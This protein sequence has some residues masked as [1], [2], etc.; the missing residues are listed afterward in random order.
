MKK[1]KPYYKLHKLLHEIE[2][3]NFWIMR[4]RAR[5]TVVKTL[6]CTNREAENYIKLALLNLNESNFSKCIKSMAPPTDCY[7][8]EYNG[9]GWLI[10]INM[11]EDDNEVNIVSFHIPEYPLHT[12]KGILTKQG[13]NPK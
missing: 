2:N 3:N 11:D 1:S 7:G 4:T 13:F 6:G 9:I 8:L 5:E 12:R 10:K